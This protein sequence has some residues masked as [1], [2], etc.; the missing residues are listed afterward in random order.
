MAASG[1]SVGEGQYP[2]VFH[3]PLPGAHELH[4]TLSSAREYSELADWATRASGHVKGEPVKR[5]AI[6]DAGGAY[7]PLEAVEKM[8]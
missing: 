1:E 8:A 3:A 6:E 2:A 4:A 5:A 7:Q